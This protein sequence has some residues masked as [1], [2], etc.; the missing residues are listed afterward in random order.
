MAKILVVDDEEDVRTYLKFYL[1]DNGYKVRCAQNGMEGSKLLK[2]FKPDL[3]IIDIIMPKQSGITLFSK[4]RKM[5]EFKGTPIIILSAV[6]R[7]RE[8]FKKKYGALPPPDA[9]VDKPFDS[10][11]LIKIIEA[12]LEV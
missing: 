3:A 6:V 2:T 5:K 4:M 11:K 12:L 8:Q 7:Y 10:A 9:F 1:E